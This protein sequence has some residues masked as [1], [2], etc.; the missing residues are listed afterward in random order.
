MIKVLWAVDLSHK[1]IDFSMIAGILK[2][3]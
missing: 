3:C 2:P 1:F